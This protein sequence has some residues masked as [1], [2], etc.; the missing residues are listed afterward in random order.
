MA[1]ECFKTLGHY[2]FQSDIWAF[3]VLMWEILCRDR[4]YEGLTVGDICS[5]VLSGALRLELPSDTPSELQEIF[6]AC[7]SREP[8]KRGSFALH[9]RSLKLFSQSLLPK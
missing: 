2:S 7:Q 3:G 9:L 4:P 1:P 6:N 5:G 8:E